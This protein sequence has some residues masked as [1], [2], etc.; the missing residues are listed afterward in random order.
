MTIQPSVIDMTLEREGRRLLFGAIMTKQITRRNWL[1][2]STAALGW[3]LAGAPTPGVSTAAFE[4]AEKRRGPVRL[5]YNENPY[6]PS[7]KATAA[8]SAQLSRGNRYAPEMQ[9]QLRE[10]IARV[11]G[12]ASANVVLGGG[13]SEVLA[14]A[15]SLAAKKGPGQLLLANPTFTAWLSPAGQYG[16]G[17]KTIA[18]DAENRHDLGT[19]QAAINDQTRLVYICNPANPCG[20]TIGESDLREF[21]RKAAARTV[22]LVDEAYC[23]YAGGGSVVGMAKDFP[24]LIV[25]R[26]FSKIYGLAGLRVGYGVGQAETVWRLSARQGWPNNGVSTVSIA[27]ALASLQDTELVRETRERNRQ[28]MDYTTGVLKELNLEHIR[29]KTNF[30]MFDV[31]RLK[32]NMAD[33]LRKRG[34]LVRNWT[35][36]GKR[37]C[38]V[39]I[40]TMEEMVF[41]AEQLR[42]IVKG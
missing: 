36:K 11:H 20:T 8:M 29:S 23:E 1:Q 35:L 18:V 16:L 26:T 39:S 14:L 41:F 38:R 31:D 2:T 17:L 42:Y 24:N 7:P 40:G 9:E 15:T 3:M 25:T 4:P 28:A 32:V 13:S 34:V 19:M 22:A 12:V 5:C 10:A 21:I 6:G 37:F 27:A 30:L 33:A